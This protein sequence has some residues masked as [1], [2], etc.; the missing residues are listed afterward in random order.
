MENILISESG[1]YQL[2]DFGSATVKVVRPSE[3]ERLLD[4]EEEIKRYT[5][6]S[7]RA[8]EMV[9]LYSGR[10]IMTKSDIWALGCLLYKLAF[11]Q[12]PFG[13]STLAI[14]NG[15]FTIPDTSRYSKGLHALIRWTLEPNLDQRPDIYQVSAMVCRLLGRKA[16]DCP[17]VNVNGSQVSDS[18]L[19]SRKLMKIPCPRFLIW[20]H[21]PHR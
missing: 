19:F 9:D 17:V 16:S 20:I 8:P 5:T 7:Y 15:N 14:Q 4:V 6:L 18:L 21:W 10:P 12:L 3:E 2:C 13:E 11:F 1:S